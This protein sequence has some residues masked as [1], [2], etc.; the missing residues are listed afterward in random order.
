[1]VQRRAP[2]SVTRPSQPASVPRATSPT[3]GLKSGEHY[4]ETLKK[5][6]QIGKSRGKGEDQGRKSL[7][8]ATDVILVH[9]LFYLRMFWHF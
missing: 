5:A 2:S 6:E 8:V 1:M 4:T 7:E 3:R 9:V